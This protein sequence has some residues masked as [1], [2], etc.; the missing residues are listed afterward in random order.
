MSLV[1]FAQADDGPI[2]VGHTVNLERR[3]EQI[4][5][6]APA[7]IRLVATVAGDRRTEAYFHHR[8]TKHRAY[9]E[10]YFPVP[11]VVGVVK[12]VAKNGESVIP[13]EFRLSRQVARKVERDLADIIASAINWIEVIATPAPLDEKISERLARVAETAGVS[14]RSVKALWYGE[15]NGISAHT[16]LGLKDAFDTKM[17]IEAARI[18][19][20]SD[21]ARTEPCGGHD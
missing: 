6:C 8:L 20:A 11:D 12:S 15:A 16:Y 9:G 13:P 17:A 7:A 5:T 4:Q 2:K 18:L 10:W 14:S 19:G 3:L 1:Y 21:S